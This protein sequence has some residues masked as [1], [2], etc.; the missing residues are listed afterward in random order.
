ML[1]KMV[2]ACFCFS[3]WAA[4]L[5]ATHA[6]PSTGD[7]IRAN[8]APQSWSMFD[9]KLLP[10]EPRSQPRATIS[11]T[12]RIREAAAAVC[13]YKN[14]RRGAHGADGGEKAS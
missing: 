6:S 8:A 4:Y 5:A 9:A 10:K 2:V 7:A 14:T 11:D 3:G 13:T 12:I 1:D